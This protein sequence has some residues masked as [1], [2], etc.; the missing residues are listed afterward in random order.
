MENAVGLVNCLLFTA[1]ISLVCFNDAVGKFIEQSWKDVFNRE[2]GDDVIY[3][4]ALAVL[5]GVVV[6]II[7]IKSLLDWQG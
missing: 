6:T 2:L 1:G 7:S 4:R 5:I 3:F